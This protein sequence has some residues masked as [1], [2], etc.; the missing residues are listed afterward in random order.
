ME[1]ALCTVVSKNHLPY[2]RT[3]AASFRQ[4]HPGAPMFVLLADQIDGYF[5]PEREPFDV[6]ELSALRIPNLR[7]FCFQYN[8]AELNCAAKP[9]LLQYLLEKRGVSKLLYLDS[10]ILVLGDLAEVQDLLDTHA[11]LLTP[12]LIQEVED[13]HRKPGEKHILES[14]VYNAGFIGV[15]NHSAAIRFVAWWS[16]RV[17]TGCIADPRIG[18][19]VDQR[20]L[21]LVPGMFHGVHIIRHPGYNVGH[22]SLSHRTFETGG[23]SVL[24]NGLPLVVFHFSGLDLDRLER[25]SRHQDRF[26][27][28]EVRPL[29]GLFEMYRERVMAAG[30]RETQEWPYAFGYFTNGVPVP[31][32][33]RRLY[34]KLGDEVQRFGD[35]FDTGR[36]GSFWQWINDETHP[37][38]GVSRLWYHVYMTRPDVQKAL[39]DVFGA[40]RAT[41]LKWAQSN[42]RMEQQIDE[43]FG[44]P[45]EAVPSPAPPTVGARAVPPAVPGLNIAGH[46][47]SEKG[48]GE[49]LRATVRAV[50]AVG[51]PHVVVDFPD[52]TSANTDRTRLGFLDYNPHPVNV[53]HVNADGL[54]SF[55]SASGTKFLRGKYNIGF[56]MWELP[57]LPPVLLAS[58][59]YLDEVWVASRY[60]LEAISSVSSVP[61]VKIPLALPGG[62]LVTKNVGRDYFG[63]PEGVVIFLFM[64][65]VHSVVARKN[66]SGLITAFKRAFGREDDVRLVLKLVHGDRKIRKALSDEAADS[67]VVVIDRVM[68][69]AEIN[70]LIQVSDCYVSLHRSEG[71]GM[72]MAEA[73][74]LG[75][76]VVATAYSANVDFMTPNNSFLVGYELVQLEKDYGPYPRGSVWADPDL[77]H[78]SGLM[79]H[80]Y[81]N[82]EHAR[83][84]AQRG[85]R[86]IWRYL[87]PEAVGERIVRRLELIG[88]R[89]DVGAGVTLFGR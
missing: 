24:V 67:R 15:R 44:P 25:I 33:V 23:G 13:D 76:P 1:L 61:V 2:A 27:L 63:L 60:C 38:S 34:W 84:V 46:A 26:S 31:A 75:K 74:A 54:P 11:I 85:S 39:P 51:L 78:A 71:F 69:R 89:L 65:D 66:P 16:Q 50:T 40:D 57:E 79:R 83:E 47:M 19:F 22:W 87:S 21:D 64:F 3:L 20:W 53:I 52:Q 14:G 59:A 49:A 58:F 8:I 5:A 7:R 68:E 17:Y 28:Y 37:G 12:H 43:A 42:G 48:M 9:Y 45:P 30:Y 18:L 55:V 88:G 82:R 35:P 41:F 29:Q 72:T 73:M 32:D 80:V 56:W 10:D 77:G 36:Q 4:Y 86:D 62:G 70:S 6:I 81:E